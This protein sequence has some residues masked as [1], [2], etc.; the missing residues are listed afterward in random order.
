[1]ELTVP[2]SLLTWLFDRYRAEGRPMRGCEP[3]DLLERVRDTCRFRRI[4]LQ[5]TEKT[6]SLAWSGYF[7]AGSIADG[8]KNGNGHA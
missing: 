3:R 8:K 6:L 7:G 2:K 4:P 5:L 1:M